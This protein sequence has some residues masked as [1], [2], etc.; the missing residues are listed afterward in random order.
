M[1]QGTKYKQ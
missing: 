1:N